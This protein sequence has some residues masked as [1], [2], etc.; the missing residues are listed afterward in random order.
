MSYRHALVLFLSIITHRAEATPLIANG[1]ADHEGIN[2]RG[3]LPIFSGDGSAFVLAPYVEYALPNLMFVTGIAVGDVTGDGLN[4]VVASINRSDGDPAA[5]YTVMVFV[6]LKNG[7]LSAVARRPTGIPFA[8][9]MP[10]ILA[11]LDHTNGLDVVVGWPGGVVRLL[12]DPNNIL[13]PPQGFLTNE[14]ATVL[15]PVDIK[16]D[17]N[18]D[19]VSLAWAPSGRT[20]FSDGHGDLSDSIRFNTT[21]GGY[22]KIAYRDFNGDQLIDVVVG[23]SQS[24]P[25]QIK[26]HLQDVKGDFLAGPTIT[27][28]SSLSVNGLGFS[29]FNRDG[30]I[31]LAFT[32]GGDL[33]NAGLRLMFQDADG[34][35]VAYQDL[36]T[37][38]SAKALRAVDVNLDGYDDVV[39]NH[40]A[41]AGVYLQKEN[42][43]GAEQHYPFRITNDVGNHALEVADVNGD[44][45]PDVVV[46]GYSN[47][48][49]TV[50]TGRGC[51]D[52]LLSS[53]FE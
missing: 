38:A 22:N 34:G 52:M 21:V 32:W 27:T 17:G 26:I 35:L 42:G 45:C 29:D 16:G 11:D 39:V 44:G 43:L 14:S 23:S 24:P 53:G 31:D 9:Q 28:P 47:F 3:E 30:R 50:L 4:D 18:V 51:S 40:M 2:T 33:P 25:P 49:I 48:G 19:V 8:N 20:Y 37:G 46:T 7:L 10:V 5:A 13:G 15:A 41:S 12:S 1:Q 6:Q 36:L